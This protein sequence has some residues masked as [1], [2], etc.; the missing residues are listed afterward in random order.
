[1]VTIVEEKNVLMIA[2]EDRSYLQLLDGEEDFAS[3][4][5]FASAQMNTLDQVANIRLVMITATIKDFVMMGIVF[6]IRDS[7]EN[8]VKKLMKL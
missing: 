5:G 4:M 1:M 6:V 2:K 7:Q 3:L 8:C